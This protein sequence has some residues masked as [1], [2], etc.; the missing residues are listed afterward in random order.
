MNGPRPALSWPIE[1]AKPDAPASPFAHAGSNLVLDFHGD[2]RIARLAIFSDGNHHMALEEA[3]TSF[4]AAHPDA[5]DVFYATTP[6]R[7]LIEALAIGAIRVGNLTLSVRPHVFISP[8]DVIGQLAAGGAVGAPRR[9]MR[10]RGNVLL[11]RRGNPKR[12]SGL[13]DLMRDDVRLAL[14]NPK[15]EAA[16]YGVYRETLTGLALERGMD[17]GAFERLLETPGRVRHSV[18][19]HHREIPQILADDLAD[20]A[21][22][23]YHLALRYTRIFEGLFEIV[24]LSPLVGEPGA[25]PAN[26]VTEYHAA[27]VGEGGV[28]GSRLLDHLMGDGVTAIYARHGLAR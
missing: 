1:A 20:A 12:I 4:L 28:F 14:S 7:V 3:L 18:S 19:I 5:D 10:S 2:P 23:Y 9:F 21:V 26:R 6:P 8:A 17:A 25:T 11:V 15:T 16:S 13:G 24:R 27:L 22:V